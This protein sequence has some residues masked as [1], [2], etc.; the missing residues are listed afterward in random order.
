MNRRD[1]LLVLVALGTTPLASRAQPA[2]K[3]AR[4]VVF[5]FGG[6]VTPATS[7]FFDAFKQGLRELG[8]IEGKNVVF[9]RRSTSDPERLPDLAKEIVALKPDVILATGETSGR[10]AQQATTT[11]PIVL[12]YSTD[13]VG[14]GFARSL[15]RPGGNVTGLASLAGDLG[16]KL[17]ELLLTVVPKLPRVAVLA[18]P[19]VSSYAVVLKNLQ[20]AAQSVSVNLLSLEAQSAVE[21]DNAFARMAREGVS[22][23]VVPGDPL[24]FAQRHQ[25]A[26]LALKNKTASVFP[27]RQHVDAGGLMSYGVN[28]KDGFRRAATFVDKILKGAK[29]GDLPFEQAMTLELAINLKTAKVLGIKFP[30]SVLVRADQVIE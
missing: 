1:T 20:D 12:A 24:V 19:S 7:V 14:G 6:P 10:A 18:N 13:P 8:Y 29:P 4:I 2:A 22:A 9:E 21:I 16:P 28:I 15:A 26:E 27:A 5:G 11:I 3:S 25:I 23:V 30:Q 17:L